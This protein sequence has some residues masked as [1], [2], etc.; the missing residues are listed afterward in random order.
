[1]PWHWPAAALTAAVLL[2]ALTTEVGVEAAGSVD[3]QPAPSGP[4]A[5][6]ATQPA[7]SSAARA[8]AAAKS[9]ASP[10]SASSAAVPPA[11]ALDPALTIPLPGDTAQTTAARQQLKRADDAYQL[12][13][14]RY[15]EASTATA[16][17]IESLA[18][19]RTAAT[20]ATTRARQAHEDFIV[21]VNAQYESGSGAIGAARLL[22]ADSPHDLLSGLQLDQIAAENSANVLAA[23]QQT[24]AAAAAAQRR[25][26]QAQSAA[27]SAQ[28]R[29][30]A[31]LAAAAQAVRAAQDAV[32]QLHAADLARARASEQHSLTAAADAIRA[33]ALARRAARPNAFRTARGPAQAIAIAAR[34]VLEQAARGGAAAKVPGP[35]P[36]LGGS[37]PYTG[38]TGSGPVLALTRFDGVVSQAGWPNPGVGTKVAGTAPF[39]KSD[40]SSVHPTM[41]AYR[42]GYVPLRAEVAVDS[43]LAELGSPYVWDAAGPDTFD[44]SG[45]TLWAW[46]HA[47]VPLEHFTGTQ[48]T[49][50]MAVP[51]DQLLPGDLLLFGTSLH[52]V[53]MYLGAGFM[54][55]APTTGDY[56]KV[57]PVADDGDFA[58][59]VRP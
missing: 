52:H 54:I 45:L 5:P 17:A 3:A 10:A 11:V 30:D 35:A 2:V 27:V 47:G 16:S 33:E 39:R 14:Q 44:C 20:A 19:A 12:A 36:A 31:Q 41:P 42:K 49:Q 58:V 43:A 8:H 21:M 53:G 4:S 24:Q 22:L 23:A 26:A 13:N 32:A 38:A 6:A 50:G 48:V 37:V 29:A 55:D 51:P 28:L 59:A 7:R 46:G 57:Q 18:A 34:A 9:N 25:L 56:V 15:D 1:M 40:G